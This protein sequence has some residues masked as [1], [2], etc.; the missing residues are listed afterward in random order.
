MKL[1]ATNIAANAGAHGTEIDMV[2][3][4]LVHED[5]ISVNR[6]HDVLKLVRSRL[7]KKK[8]RKIVKGIE[9]KLENVHHKDFEKGEKNI[10][11]KKK[12]KSKRR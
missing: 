11:S 2:A 9:K 12:A 6:A 10:R 7:R 5:D 3:R 1:H 4:V 8:I